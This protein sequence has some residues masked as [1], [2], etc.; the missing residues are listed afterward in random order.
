MRHRLPKTIALLVLVAGASLSAALLGVTPGLPTTTFA[1]PGTLA[2]TAANGALSIST[3]PTAM[4]FDATPTPVV[5]I[6]G[7]AV[8]RDL[9]INIRLNPDG[10]VAGGPAGADLVLRGRITGP[11][12]TVYDGTTLASP[13]LTGEVL[14]FGYSDGAIDLYDFVFT[15]TGGLLLPFYAGKDIAVT[16]QSDSQNTFAGVFTTNFGGNAKGS[17]GPVPQEVPQCKGT[18]GDFVWHDENRNGIQEPNEHGINGVTVTLTPTSPAGAAQTTVTGLSPT[19]QAGYYQFRDL[20]QGT[21]QVTATTP[22]G[23]SETISLVPP[24]DRDSNGSPTTVTLPTRDSSDQTID[25]GFTTPCTG[26]IGDYVW[27][28]LNDNGI[29]EAGETGQNGVLVQL[30]DA[31]GNVLA[32]TTTANSPN[33]GQPGTTCSTVCVPAPIR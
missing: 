24:P 25:F 16:V 26:T 28:D 4:R 22:S 5:R 33:T 9:A 30:L 1:N 27:T 8:T 17:L 23:Y 2:Y 31:G 21:Y 19:G 12:G 18:I 6:F 13:L 15:P 7:T 3:T 11:D 29:Q 20:C 32:S 10:T 14:K